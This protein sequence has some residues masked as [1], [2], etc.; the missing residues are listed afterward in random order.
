MNSSKTIENAPSVG[1]FDFVYKGVII[2]VPAILNIVA[3][4]RPRYFWEWLLSKYRNCKYISMRYE[5]ILEEARCR[6]RIILI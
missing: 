1:S 5:D 6:N 2:R 3:R 4:S